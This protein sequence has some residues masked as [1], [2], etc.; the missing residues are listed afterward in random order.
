MRYLMMFLSLICMRAGAQDLVTYKAGLPEVIKAGKEFSVT[1]DMNIEAGHHI[2]APSTNNAGAGLV[3]TKISFEL[4]DGFS[5]EGPPKWPKP[6][7]Y[8]AYEVFKGSS[9]KAV[10]ILKAGKPGIYK[11]KMKIRYQV[12]NQDIC[13]APRTD[14]TVLEINVK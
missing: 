11:V 10:Q 4:P 3:E 5:K 9:V 2:Y 12:C 1:V 8:G 6:M 14:E 13:F 7:V